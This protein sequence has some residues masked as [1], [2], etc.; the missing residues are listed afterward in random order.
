VLASRHEYS[1]NYDRDSLTIIWSF[2]W[3]PHAIL[4]GHNPLVTHDVWAPIGVNLT[5]TVTAPGLALI[6][7]PLTLIVGA[8]PSFDVA[9]VL[10][11]AAAAWTAFLLCRH[12][13]RAFW[14]SL[15]GGFL[16]GFS[17]YMLAHQG[18]GHMNLTSIFLIPLVALV[19]LRYLDG[20][21]G[22]RGLVVRL[23]PL[24]AL[25]LLFST[26]IVFTVSL[27]LVG[28]LLLA[29]AMVPGR[30]PELRASAGP[31]V[32]SF[33]LAGVLTAPF[34]YF[35]VK[36]LHTSSYVPPA[37]YNTDLLNLVVPTDLELLGRS[38]SSSITSHF[39]GNVT[40]TGAF[41]GPAI[42]FV[43]L[44]ARRAWRS[45]GGRFL[46]VAVAIATLAALG[47]R[48]VVDGHAVVWLP[49]SLVVHLPLWDNVL[50]T[51]ID[52]YV[53]LGVAVMTALWVAGQRTGLLRFALPVVAAIALLPNPGAGVWAT[54]YTVPAFFT[55]PAY[56][57][58]LGPNELVL[59]EPIG[60]DG[61]AM[62]W[63]EEN[64]FRFKMAGGH[65]QTPPS[66]FMHP[67]SLEQV[68]G[69]YPIPPSRAGLFRNF[70]RFWGVTSVVADPVGARPWLPALGRLAKPQRVGGILLYRVT[71][72]AKPCIAAKR[73]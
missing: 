25:Q 61:D 21:L 22:G 26:E 2:A 7:A 42:L 16:Y 1:G 15:A 71:P 45:A 34:L 57:G 65:F 72:G 5:W 27:A 69:A 24:L 54:A 55:D 66:P 43:A 19:V 30:R 6:F 3:Y 56:R 38:W 53:W 62:L 68:T 70:I 36:G 49:W 33:A 40:E 58:C 63:Q 4:H 59:P 29:F 35:L 73:V 51:R 44:Y 17:G 32:F 52:Q 23:G 50:P 31:I 39:P 41:L 37:E 11:P 48:L 14:P 8:V 18:G 13:T 60:T 28:G 47:P 20:G 9:A 64:A 12:L 10:L 46:L 67:Q